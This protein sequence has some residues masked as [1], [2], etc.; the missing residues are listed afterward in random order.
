ME[1]LNLDNILNIVNIEKEER[2]LESYAPLYPMFRVHNNKLY[3]A[4]MISNINT[5]IWNVDSNIKP[6]YWCL[7]DINTLKIIEFNK[8][9]EKDYQVS[10]FSNKDK[11]K[12]NELSKYEKLK[13]EEYEQYFMNDIL[14]KKF[15]LYTKSNL[16]I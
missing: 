16:N 5:D 10:I 13:Q 3:I 12:F 6:E 15:E 7:I 11:D 1:K 9:E 4:V 8:I 14:N 2:G